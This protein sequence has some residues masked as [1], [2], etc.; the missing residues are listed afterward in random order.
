[1][2]NNNERN[3]IMI[4]NNNR[5][6]FGLFDP[7]FDDFFVTPFKREFKEMEHSMKTDVKENEN[8]YELEVEMPGYDK[9]DINLNLENGYLTIS[10]KKEQN[11]DEK[12][13]HG[14]YI[15]RERRYGS[16]SRS[17]YVGEIKQE[18]IEAKLEH[19]VLNIVI[20]KEKKQIEQTKR[21]EIK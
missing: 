17:F 5:G 9:Q 7:F 2:K 16:C 20:P 4:R 10:A 1:M 21:I 3:D 8:N 19:G 6:E 14:N 18:D 11:N 12:D 15:R 13:K